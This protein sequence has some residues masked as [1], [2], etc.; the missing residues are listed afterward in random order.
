MTKTVI[1]T[2]LGGILIYLALTLL[3]HFFAQALIYFPPRPGYI[4]DHNI[5]KLKT[6][7]GATISAIYLK[8]PAS[9][10]TV[11]ISHGNAEDIG[12]MAPFFQEWQK[13]GFAIF[14]YD[15]HGYGTSTGHPSETTSYTDIDAAYTYLTKELNIPPN[16]IILYG[17]SIGSAM[18]LDLAI[19]HNDDKI[20]AI[21]ME[22]PFVTAYRVVTHIPLFA[23][24][25]FDNLSK[26]SKLKIPLLIIHGTHD[27]IVPFWHGV[28]LY[29]TAPNKITKQYFW[30]SGAG[31]NNI[32]WLAKE[33]YWQE[34][35]NFVKLL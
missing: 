16:K 25:K 29:Q 10:Y 22:S 14:A 12:Y 4:D 18:A 34:V 11:L 17:R 33:K 8:N 7:D 23:F 27:N 9:K 32:L 24:D 30:V 19:R 31:H 35:I 2:L 3:L 13:H 28:K 21:I 20:A 6:R 26:I 1:M 15:Y 5:I